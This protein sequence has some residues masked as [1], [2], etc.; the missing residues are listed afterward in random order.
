MAWE[1]RGGRGRYYTRIKKVR[2]RYVRE[3]VGGGE[4]GEQAAAADARARRERQTRSE[5]RRARRKQQSSLDH[6]VRALTKDVD[7]LVKAALLGAG[8]HRH[9]GEWRERK[10]GRDEDRSPQRG[11]ALAGGDQR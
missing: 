1:T 11:G 6:L 10:H 9:G 4:K 2:G 3:Y 8:Y 5:H 7:L